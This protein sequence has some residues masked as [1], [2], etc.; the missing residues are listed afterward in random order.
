MSRERDAAALSAPRIVTSPKNIAG[1][2][3]AAAGPVLVLAGVVALPV[4]LVLMPALYAI[5]ALAAP[6]RRRVVASSGMDTRE[7]RRSLERIQRRTLYRVPNSIAKNVNAI[8]ETIKQILPRL[9]ALPAGSPASFVI[10]QCAVDYL[11]NA[12]QPYLDLPRGYADHHV[13]ATG[14]TPLQ[15]LAYQLDLLEREVKE[16]ATDIIRADTDRL[17]ANGRFLAEKFGDGE[18]DPRD[19]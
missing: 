19:N 13:L 8:V 18:L 9:D 10:G 17:L 12:L 2:A 3:V 1:C 14:K 6:P 15:E 4:G 11:P 16:I 7:V 5:G